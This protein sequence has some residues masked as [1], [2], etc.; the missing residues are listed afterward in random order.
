MLSSEN[1]KKVVSESADA[2]QESQGLLEPGGWPLF[3]R[4]DDK[5]AKIS[6]SSDS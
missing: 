5:Q 6:Q 4:A 1:G 2:I 3:L